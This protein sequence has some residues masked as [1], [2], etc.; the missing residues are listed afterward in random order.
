MQNTTTTIDLDALAAAQLVQINKNKFLNL[1]FTTEEGDVYA[2]AIPSVMARKLKK[3]E[4]SDG[5]GRVRRAGFSEATEESETLT[6]EGEADKDG[7]TSQ[8]TGT[9]AQQEDS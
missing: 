9:E 7:D 1:V 5:E 4:I 6:S 3:E 8:D 2:I